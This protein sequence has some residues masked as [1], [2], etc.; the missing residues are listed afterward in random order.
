MTTLNQVARHRE[1]QAL[2]DD[3][4]VFGLVDGSERK[5]YV[6]NVLCWISLVVIVVST[7]RVIGNPV[8]WLL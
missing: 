2:A 6:V 3:A 5:D 4:E 8:G 1:A 7:A